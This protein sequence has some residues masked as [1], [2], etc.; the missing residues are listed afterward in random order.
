MIYI[1][2]YLYTINY[3]SHVLDRFCV[4]SHRGSHCINGKVEENAKS[5]EISDQHGR[6]S[7]LAQKVSPPESVREEPQREENGE[8]PNRGR[9]R[10]R[11]TGQKKMSDRRG[12]ATCSPLVEQLLYSSYLKYLF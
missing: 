3:V 4:Q 12:S 9:R 6:H 11:K 7:S 1:R 10:R 2:L 5:P 8:N